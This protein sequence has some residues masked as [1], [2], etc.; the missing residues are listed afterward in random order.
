MRV[1]LV[2]IY[3][4]NTLHR[5]LSSPV[6]LA[7]NKIWETQFL[8]VGP[9]AQRSSAACAALVEH[10]VPATT[11]HSVLVVDPRPARVINALLA[12][13]ANTWLGAVNPRPARVLNALH[14]PPANTW[15]GAVE[16]RPARVLNALLVPQ[17][18]T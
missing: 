3:K 18:N 5:V 13:Q 11:G 6:V 2:T 12:P 1:L 16:H 7:V 10:V 8:I 9:D 14:V 17:A 15:P 4:V